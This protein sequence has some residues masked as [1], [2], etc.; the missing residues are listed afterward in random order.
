[1]V[2]ESEDFAARSS[3]HRLREPS[4]PVVKAGGLPP[5]IRQIGGLALGVALAFAL[6]SAHVYFMK[7]AGKSLDQ[8]FSEQM[9]GGNPARAIEQAGGDQL[10][11]GVDRTCRKRAAEAKLTSAQ[12]NATGAFINLHAG[13]LELAGAATYVVCLLAERTERL[14]KVPDRRH[15]A[16]AVRQYLKRI[17]EVREAWRVAIEGPHRGAMAIM[18]NAGGGLN[19]RARPSMPSSQVDPELIANLRKLAAGGLVAAGDF[20]GF[21]GFGVPRAI[22]EA[23]RGVEARKASCG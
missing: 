20:G 4:N 9:T 7:Q 10:M 2:R 15:L 17:D 18:A 14:C 16:E 1:M 11:Q 13:E 5:L 19:A 12:A 8:Q 22:T 6:N 21:A 23:L 3:A